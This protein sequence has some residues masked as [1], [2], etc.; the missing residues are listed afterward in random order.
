MTLVLAMHT[1]VG[2]VRI[3]NLID[4]RAAARGVITRQR[5]NP[6]PIVVRRLQSQHRVVN[7]G[8]ERL[9]FIC[10]ALWAS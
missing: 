7:I 2:V 5:L 6:L 3:Q 1:T 9:I 4:D 8:A 10:I